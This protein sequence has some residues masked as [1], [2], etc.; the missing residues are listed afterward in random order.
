M[1]LLRHLTKA[2][3][4]SF[5][6]SWPEVQP[7]SIDDERIRVVH[8]SSWYDVQEAASRLRQDFNEYGPPCLI[9]LYILDQPSRHGDALEEADDCVLHNGTKPRSFVHF[10]VSHAFSDGYCSVPLIQDF[11]ALYCQARGHQEGACALVPLPH[12][13]TFQALEDRFLSTLRG[14]PPLVSPE[15]I[16]LRAACFD[17]S[18]EPR[19]RP[20]VYS[21]EMLIERSAVGM[22]RF[23]AKQYGMPTDVTLLALV[24]V[25]MS[26]SSFKT[27][28][29][30]RRPMNPFHLTF[31][32]PMR[33][34]HLNDAMV[35]LF[36]DWR[37]M[38]VPWSTS[39]TVLGFSVDLAENIR[40]RRW[41]VFDPICNSE[42][43]LVNILPLDEQVRGPQ[44]F[45][46]TRLHEYGN[47][48]FTHP[49]KRRAD[50]KHHHRPA[51]ITLEQEAVDV[52]W[53]NM[54]LNH[55]YFSTTWCRCFARELR[56]AFIDLGER[57]LRQL[58]PSA[59]TDG[60]D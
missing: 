28:R 56:Q 37:D 22:L 18:W 9:G 51:R 60:S 33:D 53:I 49:Q 35:G 25:A 39:A 14:E 58:I 50:N 4:W 40:H 42:R 31:Y 24:L 2:A 8:C 10:V 55:E 52:W 41:E 45:C 59:D 12:G 48:R 29:G 27:G 15:Q 13:Q 32:V 57:P 46:Q 23:C 26:R 16:S 30:K 1:L 34:G 19:W 44:E 3:G 11:A 20:W 6:Q 47:R 21:H 5:F 38:S 17:E 54:E 36:S 7:V 43:I